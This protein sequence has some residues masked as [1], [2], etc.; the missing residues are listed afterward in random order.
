MRQRIVPQ[1]IEIREKLK[2]IFVS[3][4]KRWLTR[5]AFIRYNTARIFCRPQF[6][7]NLLLGRESRLE[8]EDLYSQPQKSS[9]RVFSRRASFD[10]LAIH[11]VLLQNSPRLARKSLAHPEFSVMNTD[12]KLRR[13]PPCFVP[14]SPKSVSA[15]RSTAS[16]SVWRP[17]TAARCWPAAAPRAASA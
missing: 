6:R 17:A 10:F 12:S 13:C 2:K 4:R 7:K 3:R 15:P 8:S 1:D 16:A 5:G 9:G 14:I 11:R